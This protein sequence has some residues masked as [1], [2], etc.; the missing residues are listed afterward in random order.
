MSIELNQANKRLVWDFWTS[1]EASGPD[2]AEHVAASCMAPNMPWHGPDPINDLTGASEFADPL[3]AA[4]AERVS[5]PA[6]QLPHVP[7][8]AP[9]VAMPDGQGDGRMWVG[10][11][12]WFT[13]TF[14]PGL[15]FHF[16][17]WP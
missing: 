9:P 4:V 14:H 5:R 1:L 6:P 3:L 10:G 7:W 2:A 15:A 16:A 13:G 11:T 12:G 8:A 17:Q